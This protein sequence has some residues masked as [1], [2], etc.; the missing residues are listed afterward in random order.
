M[1]VSPCQ[2]KNNIKYSYMDNRQIMT[3]CWV[4]DLLHT[5]ST[6]N[7]I[8][9]NGTFQAHEYFLPFIFVYSAY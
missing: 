6:T 9:C 7:F 5:Y 3:D 4:S 1:K 2:Y 8:L